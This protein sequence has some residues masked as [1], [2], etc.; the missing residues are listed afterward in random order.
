MNSYSESIQRFQHYLKKAISVMQQQK[1]QL[2]SMSST[3]EKQDTGQKEIMMALMKYEE[4]GLAYYTDQDS[5]QRVLTHGNNADLKERVENAEKKA[6]NPY[7][8]AYIWMKGELLDVQGMFDCLQGR[9]GVMKAQLST[10]QK[11]KDD[12][13]ELSKLSAGKTTF[14]SLLKSKSQKESN[15]LTLQASIEIADQEIGDFKKLI[16][17]LTIYHGQQAIPKFKIAKSKLY[18]KMLNTFCVK[19]ISN[20]HLTATLFHSLL[21]LGNKE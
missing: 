4:V 10:E 20:A 8:D 3:R 21:E 2:K 12:E 9:E 18:L 17:F 11:K 15:I 14:K 16:T 6:K 5:N 13:K 1:R 19:E 7:R